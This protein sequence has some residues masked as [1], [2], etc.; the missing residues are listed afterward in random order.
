MST[1]MSRRSL[2]GGAVA[3]A[4]VALAAPL[5][6]RARAAAAA[7]P[8]RV[9]IVIEGNGIYTRAFLS[10]AA[11]AAINA[12]AITPITNEMITD[13]Q[14]G[15]QSPIVVA[16]SGL[17]SAQS[18]GALATFGVDHK[19]AVVLGLSNTIGGGGHSAFQGGLA[20][21]RGSDA[22]APGI[23]IDAL[24]A[25]R[26]RG[27]TPFDVLRLGVSDYDTRLSYVNCALGPAHPAVVSTNPV[28]AYNRVFAAMV[29]G[30]TDPAVI[31]RAGAL[32]YA[33]A[34]VTAALA[35]F[36]GPAA[37]RA[38][39][40]SYFDAIDE[41]QRRQTRLLELRGTVAPPT[42]PTGDAT[43]PYLSTDPMD[44]LAVQ[45]ELATAALVGG[46]TN[47]A[48]LVSGTGGG[49]SLNY[50]KIFES[51]PGWAA[52]DL[53]MDRHKLQHGIQIPVHQEA[54]LAVTR[55]HVRLVAK[56]ARKLEDT[57][58]IGGG[59]MLDHTVVVFLSDNGEEHHS[60]A[61]EWPML[62]V[63]GGAMGLHTDGRTVVYPR[64]GTPNNRQVSNL[65]NTVGHA[66]G[67]PTLNTFGAER[68]ARIAPGPLSEIYSGT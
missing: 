23:T 59:T 61:R 65:W 15:H 37:E 40:Q 4:G 58:D 12:T 68:T 29:G 26:L 7:A 22:R 54:I 11:K 1:T 52:I 43:D 46:L 31:Q 17:A 2:L 28:D 47:V 33:R 67:D 57:P 44:R 18:L 53:G 35:R 38:K 48:V 64:I 25:Q 34:D 9:V 66:T 39:L 62:V 24:L 45:F 49:L 8:A 6:D 20:C 14:Y 27:Q 63:G 50:R 32:D 42:A 36:S 56:L 16:N 41:S 3:G 60:E 51:V 55:E 5:V 10:D 13:R 19:A 30:A 21:D